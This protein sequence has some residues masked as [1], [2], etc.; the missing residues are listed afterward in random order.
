MRTHIEEYADNRETVRIGV[1]LSEKR[2]LA[3]QQ[4]VH[5]DLQQLLRQYLYCCTSKASKSMHVSL[6]PRLHT[7]QATP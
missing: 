7:S 4:D 6:T 2:V 5:N 3:R 1:R